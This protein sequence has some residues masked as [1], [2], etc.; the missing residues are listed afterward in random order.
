MRTPLAI[1]L[2]ALAVATAPVSVADPVSPLEPL[3]DAAAERLQTADPVAASKYLTGGQVED[4]P[5]E[6]QVLDNVAAAAE[7]QGADPAYVRE[8]F[9]DQIDA[10][11]SLQYSRFAHWKLD[12]AD[13]PATAPDLAATRA[14]IDGLNQTMVREIATQWPTLHASTCPAELGNALVAVVAERQLDPLY[15]DALSYATHDYCR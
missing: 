3:V 7:A 15:R 2:A 13:A 4:P 10:T 9:R 8:V 11:V 1:A 14:T 6:Q 12:P 5:R